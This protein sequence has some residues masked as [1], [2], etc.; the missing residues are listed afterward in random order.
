LAAVPLSTLAGS[1]ALAYLAAHV[2]RRL[3][4]WRNLSPE[5]I[6]ARSARIE[7]AL[8]DALSRRLGAAAAAAAGG[9]ATAAV[10]A[11]RH[12]SGRSLGASAWAALAVYAGLLL[13]ELRLLPPALWWGVAWASL[14]A[15]PAAYARSRRALDAALLDVAT[16]TG[17]T[18]LS[19]SRVGLAAAAAAGV[20][21]FAT[22]QAGV[23]IRSTL[24]LAAAA[25]VLAWNVTAPPAPRPQASPPPPRLSSSPPR[26]P[27]FAPPRAPCWPSAERAR[28]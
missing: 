3:V 27:S 16:A 11:H 7:A 28:V 12:L 19:C 10:L 22:V 23:V 6:D 15:G 21:T 18:L 1:A 20:G 4:F 26:R 14:F 17:A 25:A 8:H 9:A 24:A 13:G 5:Q 2:L